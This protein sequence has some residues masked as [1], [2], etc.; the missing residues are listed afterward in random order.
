M[1]STIQTYPGEE[2]T[3]ALPG[4]CAGPRGGCS[5]SVCLHR[6]GVQRRSR[7][8]RFTSLFPALV[9]FPR[10]FTFPGSL[11][12]HGSSLQSAD[13][14]A[15]ISTRS[16]PPSR[17]YTRLS[18]FY[19]FP[20]SF[21]TGV[22][23]RSNT[24]THKPSLCTFFH[25]PSDHRFPPIHLHA[26]LHLAFSLDHQPFP[27]PIQ[28]RHVSTLIS[29]TPTHKPSLHSLPQA[30]STPVSPHHLHT[31]LSWPSCPVRMLALTHGG[32]TSVRCV[33]AYALPAT[34]FKGR[35]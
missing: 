25:K 1:Q 13:F 34:L 35:C 20:Y 19:S 27:C 8:H 11:L 12:V 6:E 30:F 18:A 4:S 2:R 32:F 7:F 21:L 5:P 26:N 15:S 16:T 9:C 22:R 17:R 31:T 23:T 10:V 33:P 14:L 24:P 3:A 29:N 28:F